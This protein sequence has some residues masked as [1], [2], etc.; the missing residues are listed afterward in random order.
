MMNIC[1]LHWV[2]PRVKFVVLE[3]LQ[4]L[5]WEKHWQHCSQIIHNRH[6]L[7]ERKQIMVCLFFIFLRVNKKETKKK[8]EKF[9]ILKAGRKQMKVVYCKI[10]NQQRKRKEEFI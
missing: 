5:A 10:R 3:F 1:Y 9:R 6:C 4:A 7:M 8:Q 2:C